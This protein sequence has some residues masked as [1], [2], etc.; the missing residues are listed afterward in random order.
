MG[1]L[2]DKN[3]NISKHSVSYRYG[4]YERMGA[5]VENGRY[6]FRVWAPRADKVLLVGD[7]CGWDN[8]CSMTRGSDGIFEASIDVS[9]VSIGDK[10]KYK[11]HRGDRV[12]YKS[13]PY[14]YMMESYNGFAS[15]IADVD[16][17]KWHDERWIERR[18]DQSFQVYSQP[19]NVYE[20]HLGSWRR[21]HDG[22]YLTYPE[23]ARELAPYVKQMG[24]THVELM[25]ISE[26]PCDGSWGYQVGGFFSPTS[27]FGSPADFMEFIDVMHCAGVGV[28]LDWV[29]AQL[30]GDEFGLCEFDG[31]AL[32]EYPVDK[33][34]SEWGTRFFDLSRT[35]VRE[36]LLSNADFWINKYH[37]DGL[38]VDAV[39]SM[40]ALDNSI[41]SDEHKKH[42]NI[43]AREFL[44]TLNAYIKNSYPGVLTIA[45][46]SSAQKH[47][48]G[49]DNDGL[50]FDLKWNM[51]WTYDTMS[52]A[53]KGVWDRVSH[54]NK[55]NFSLSYAFDE[56]FILPISH[57]DVTGGKKSYLTKMPD[58]R[59][60]KFAGARAF[61]VYQMTHPGKKLSFMGNEFASVGEWR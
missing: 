31:E 51:G 35:E 24:Y 26:Y 5:H 57:D 3:L 59:W 61:Y 56:Q 18:A 2:C 28:I 29:P 10:Y 22:S 20:I 52:Y 60:R 55:L 6:I 43:H 25:P 19:M 48:T 37:I 1:A 39:S 47:V 14:G 27:R 9:S 17:F 8:G 44:R 7:F 23:I 30:P 42:R 46:D 41:E 34:V 21:R 50:G 53:E 32:Y 38:R 40:L 54:H 49:F 33:C 12:V 45:E 4:A 13:D 16:S 36:F 58:D 11:I 15:I